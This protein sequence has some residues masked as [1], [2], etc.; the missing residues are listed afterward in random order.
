MYSYLFFCSHDI[1][2]KNTHTHKADV[3]VIFFNLFGAR[4]GGLPFYQKKKKKIIY[5][6]I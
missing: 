3:T 6:L 4:E 2:K 5:L 1:T